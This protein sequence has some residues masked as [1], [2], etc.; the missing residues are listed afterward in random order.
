MKISIFA[1][2]LLISAALISVDGQSW[3]QFQIKHINAGMT[4]GQCSTVIAARRIVQPP[5]QVNQGFSCKTLNTFITGNVNAV[6]AICAAGGGTNIGGNYYKSNKNTFNVVV[7]SGANGK[8]PCVYNSSAIN[9]VYIVT[10]CDGNREPV[11]FVRFEKS[12]LTT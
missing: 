9:N 5:T 11:H 2:V 3:A 7:C 6:R 10:E 12:G 1:G 4:A 8:Y